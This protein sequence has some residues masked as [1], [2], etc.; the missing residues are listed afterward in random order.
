MKPLITNSDSL[1]SYSSI[2]PCGILLV[3]GGSRFKNLARPALNLQEDLEDFVGG[4]LAPSRGFV[5]AGSPC[6]PLRQAPL[7]ARIC[8]CGGGPGRTLQGEGRGAVKR[9]SNADSRGSLISRFD[10]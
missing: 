5:G 6:H 3:L 1:K 10:F 4:E 7:S 2:L 9:C 8:P